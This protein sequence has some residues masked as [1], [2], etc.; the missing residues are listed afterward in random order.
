MWKTVL[1]R[2]NMNNT[3][4]NRLYSSSTS[5]SI[6][7]N[8]KLIRNEFLNYFKDNL[9][10]TFI[11]S[12]P[13]TPLNDSSI[14]F[15]N[16][17]MNQF[18][19]I[20][21]NYYDP[22]AKKVTNSQ[23][24]IRISGKHNDL[25]IVGNDSYHHTFFE[26][27]GNWSFSDYFKEEAC[28]YAW[29]L[30]TKHYGIK[31]NSLYVTYF[32]GNEQLRLEP[33]LECRDIWLN[34]GVAKDKV[35]PFDIQ[36]NFWEMGVSGPCGPCTE[37]HIDH[38]NHSS[39]Q[40][41]R[42]NK[43]YSDLT[44][45]WNIVFIQYERLADDTMIP[46]PKYHVDTGMG[47][48]RLVALLQGKNSNY[49]TDLFQPLIKATEKYT[50]APGYRGRFFD[51]DNNLDSSYRILADHSR[52]ITVALADGM[53]PEENH[54][55][56]KI[57][58]K[59]IDTGEKVFKKEKILSE[60]SYA[61]ADTLGDVYPELQTNL[62][63]VQKIMEFEEDLFK[64]LR[65]KSGKEWRKI[66]E[67]RPELASVTDWMAPGLLNAYKYLQS[68]VEDLK[69]SKTLPGDV[70]FKLFDT[71]GLN[72]E[73]IAEF[74]EIESLQFDKED[75]QN[76]LQNV[77]YQSKIGIV[78]S[79]DIIM[80]EYTNL[81]EKNNVPKTNDTLKYEYVFVG[82]NYVFPTTESK[83]V[84]I[85]VNGNLILNNKDDA[86]S[87]G[88]TLNKGDEIGIILDKTL[89]YSVEGGQ[90]SDHATIFINDL[91]F[92]INN[93]QKR[94]AYV[95]HFGK[96]ADVDCKDLNKE[97]KIGGN[98]MVSIDPDRRKGLMQHH[99]AAH[100]LNAAMKQ[101]LHA[102][103]QRSSLVLPHS[104]KFQFNS[105]GEK[106]SLEQLKQIEKSINNVIEAN[107]FVKLKVFNSSE[108]LTENFVTLIP[109]EIYPYTDIRVVDID[110]PDLKSK[111]ACC[112]T[113]V[114]RT[115]I[116][117]HFCL[118]NYHSKGSANFTVK[119]AAGQLAESAKTAGKNIQQKVLNLR[120]KLNH[121]KL[122]Y[123]TFKSISEEIKNEINDVKEEMLI[124]YLVKME[125]LKQIEDLNNDAW[126]QAKEVEKSDII[127]K[128]KDTDPGSFIVHC[129]YN[130]PTY[131]SL[132]EIMSSFSNTPVFIIICHNG[133]I[134]A[135]CSV[136]Q[137]IACNTFNAQTWMKI[138]LEI[139][140]AEYVPIKGF[141]P[142]LVASMKSTNVSNLPSENLLCNAINAAKDF[143]SRNVKRV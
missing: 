8:S 99:T 46:L 17:G 41:M 124:P 24:C 70:A 10:H 32:G 73:T 103:Y 66:V 110:T 19:G 116:L 98:C 7:W 97:I 42:V 95:I 126:V 84:G 78:K 128:V 53:V 112:G 108:L 40:S 87:K 91:I 76:V 4:L 74:A 57:I 5:N 25:S 90:T 137:E 136:P 106:L 72:E 131:L 86:V 127:L 21:L 109:G 88:I 15:V 111:E 114:H 135:R 55:L 119:G 45:L 64:R 105:F 30:L 54:K 28:L 26:M 75:F 139:F 143:A 13:V 16:A 31:E 35:L 67:N 104:L 14:S 120:D 44:E 100:L 65:K 56:R 36:D 79:N 20:F 47:F 60:L 141:N 142:S 27:L 134:K 107:V 118:L 71:Y 34:I 117:E 50:K 48:E 125:C 18:K 82:N 80:K 93:V 37:I 133:T 3:L 6:K 22:P 113:H 69:A 101:T 123:E 63:K 130:N 122:E 23:K 11:R 138:V 61:V 77:K 81:L 94:N 83:I 62:K 38:K 96:L 29:N 59:V 58:R 2:E 1:L 140:N 92:H 43:G 85:I 51:D 129:L 115:G 39:N 9:E 33:D 12:S 102:V 89:C 49:D 132:Q 52:M 121:G 68:I